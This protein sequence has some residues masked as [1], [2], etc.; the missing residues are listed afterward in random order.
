MHLYLQSLILTY[1]YNIDVYCQVFSPLVEYQFCTRRELCVH[2]SFQLRVRTIRY[3]YPNLPNHA[4]LYL[5]TCVFI[6]H[7]CTYIYSIVVCLDRDIEKCKQTNYY[8]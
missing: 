8:I 2:R 1:I 4:Y 6:L 3:L 5:S 7:V